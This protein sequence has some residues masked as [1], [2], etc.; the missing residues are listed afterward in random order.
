VASLGLRVCFVSSYPPNRARLSEYAQNLVTALTNRQAI[1]ELYLLVDKTNYPNGT[2]PNP[3][4]K[5]YRIWQ[6]DSLFS[7]LKVMRYIIKLRPNVVHFNVSFQSFGQSK[8]TNLSGLSLILL[9]RIYGFK[10]LAGVHTFADMADL[11][12]FNIKPSI[13]NKVGI[14]VATKIILSAQN[15]VVLVKGYGDSLKQRYHHKGVL[16]IP[17]G[18]TVV[19]EPIIQSDQKSILIFGHMG[20]HKGLPIILEAFKKLQTEKP[21]VRLVVA[22]TNHPNYPN[23]LTEFIKA[24]LS[25]VEFTGYVPQ[26][27]LSAV[28]E[29]ANVVVL[30]YLAAPGTSGVFHL[31]C[32]Y[33]RPLV[34]SDLPEIRE[35]VNDDASAILV[36]PGDV[37]ALK[38]ALMKVLFNQEVAEKMGK[39]NLAFAQR[40]SWSAVAK[41]YEVA[42]FNLQ[43]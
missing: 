42:Y 12:K 24:N 38:E 40:E 35:L 32:G 26:D 7:I 25:S 28:F 9:S 1:D 34:A 30:P 41:A 33:G 27:K 16:F 20:P 21:N 8:I 19:S 29:Q 17:H 43:K 10:V 14:L 2:R 18:T 37:D 39:Q 6:G 3:K 31:A 36:P 13:V 15:V 11:E 22:G 23:Y 5:I 4:V